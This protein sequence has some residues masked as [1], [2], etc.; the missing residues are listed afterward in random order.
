MQR[1]YKFRAWDTR[2]KQWVVQGF[3]I[4]GETTLF[5]LIGIYCLENKGDGDSLERYNDIV[6]TQWT[7][8]VINGTDL[9]EGDIVQEGDDYYVCIWMRAWSMYHFMEAEK[10]LINEEVESYGADISYLTCLPVNRRNMKNI[11]H[12]GNIFE[13]RELLTK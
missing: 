8:H 13:N 7:E 9:Y 2:L 5:N 11:T 6:V 1:E 4:F 12:C 10:F 3:S